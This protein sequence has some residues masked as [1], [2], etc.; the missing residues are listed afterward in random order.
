[1]NW[2]NKLLLTFIVF[3]IGMFYLVYRSMSTHY[4]LVEKDYYNQE[5]RYQQKIDATSRTNALQS[6]VVLEQTEQGVHVQLPLEMKNKTLNGDIW[7][8]CAYDAGKDKKISLRAD[9]NARQ[10]IPLRELEPGNYT[11][12]LNWTESGQTYYAEKT[13][14]VL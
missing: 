5:L 13:L 6:A 8:Y 7:F 1:M 12:K 4:E 14:T 11:V 10:L 9:S 2:G 3:G